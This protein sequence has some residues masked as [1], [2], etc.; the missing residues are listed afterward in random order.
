[1]DGPVLAGELVRDRLLFQTSLLE[2][3]CRAL[4]YR[5]GGA[6]VDV[7]PLLHRFQAQPQPNLAR[8]VFL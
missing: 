4:A 6:G 7:K 5:W 3:R 2:I 8:V 1:M